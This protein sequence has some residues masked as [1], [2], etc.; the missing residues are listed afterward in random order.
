MHTDF[1]AELLSLIARYDAYDD[2]FWT[3]GLEFSIRCS[4]FFHW[5]CSDS[6]PIEAEDLPLLRQSLGEDEANGALLYCCRKRQMRPQGAAY[7]DLARDRWGLYD[8]C[9]PKREVGLANPQE[10]GE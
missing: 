3:D 8:R 5:G 6:E 10:P 7:R 2:L 9:G 1:I 4:D